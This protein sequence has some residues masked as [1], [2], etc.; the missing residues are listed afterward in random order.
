MIEIGPVGSDGDRSIIAIAPGPTGDNQT[1]DFDP[2][3]LG[4]PSEPGPQVETF[5]GG[6]I[7]PATSVF[8]FAP[9]FTGGVFV[10]TADVV[11]DGSAEVVD[12]PGPCGSAEAQLL[13]GTASEG[14]SVFFLLDPAAASTWAECPTFAAGGSWPPPDGCSR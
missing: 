8:A 1:T 12:A 13:S 4:I 3:T 7:T 11:G 10:A 5:D 6:S 14:A 2:L 9:T